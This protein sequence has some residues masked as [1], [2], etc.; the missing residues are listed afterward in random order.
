MIILDTNVISELMRENPDDRVRAWI[1]AQKPAKLAITT[2][3]IAEI[4]RGLKRLPKGKKRNYL[5]ASFSSFVS[6]A[7]EGRILPFD[8][9][10]AYIYGD[11]AAK[12]EKEGFNTDA[13]DLMIAA[14]VK[15]SEGLLAT[16][17]TK[18]FE[19]CDIRIINP[20]K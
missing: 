3:A 9:H 8:E 5:E 16:R 2:I 11:I 18:D 10:S 4:Q 1:G 13:I 12:R 20:W 14:I 17:I 19:G 7:F 6:K 15:S